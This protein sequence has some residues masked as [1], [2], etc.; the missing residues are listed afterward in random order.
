MSEATAILPRRNKEIKLN[1][2]DIE[3]F[4]RGVDKRG[5]DECWE[6]KKFANWGG[7]GQI[8]I[9]DI[10][11]GAHRVALTIVKGELPNGLC[12]CHKCDNRRCCNPAHLFLG[13]Y[14]DNNKDRKQKRRSATC[15]R[16]G[17]SVLSHEL[18]NL[19]RFVYWN[20][21]ISQRKLAKM[22][23]VSR[24][25]LSWVVTNRSWRDALNLIY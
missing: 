7:Y 21:G 13:T 1:E 16:A 23:G 2:K 8:T 18:V 9:N 4:W 22:L 5:D 11:V 20:G 12:V 3:R 10:S 17:R 6:W 25:T 24:P 15:E 14:D 19:I